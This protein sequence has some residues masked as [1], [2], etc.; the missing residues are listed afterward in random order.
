VGGKVTPGKRSLAPDHQLEGLI[1][2]KTYS[3]RQRTAPGFLC[4]TL[5]LEDALCARSKTQAQLIP[6]MQ[7]TH[8]RDPARPGTSTFEVKIDANVVVA[9]LAAE[10]RVQK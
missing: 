9:P 6:D 3:A 8:G 2:G 10:G 7:A 5:D 4:V 1:H